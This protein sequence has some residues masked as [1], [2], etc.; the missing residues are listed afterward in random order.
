MDNP[1]EYG[2]GDSTPYVRGAPRIVKA[3]PGLPC[4]YCR[5]KGTVFEIEVTVEN[6]KFVS[7]HNPKGRGYGKYKGCAACPWAGPMGMMEHQ[8]FTSPGWNPCNP[9]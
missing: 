7:D 5:G 4:P 1:R 3:L 9:K 6:P 2:L 8:H